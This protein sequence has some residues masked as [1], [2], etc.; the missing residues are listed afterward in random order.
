MP[1]IDVCVSA[2]SFGSSRILMDIRFSL[3]AGRATA[4][5]G[6]SGIGKTTLLRII[7]G[8]DQHFDGNISGSHRIGMVFQEPRLLP[9]LTASQNVEIV[10]ATPARAEAL[11]RQVGLPDAAALYPRQLS[12]GMARRAALARALAVEPELLILDEPFASLDAAAAAGLRSLVAELCSAGQ[13]TVL[14]V[15]HDSSDVAALADRALILSGRPA[16]LVN[17]MRFDMP[18]R[19]RGEQEHDAIAGRLK[20]ALAAAS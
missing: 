13:M 5:L 20:A 12:L 15:S 3:E 1:D 7:A 10:G 2:K 19:Q 14:I 18:P 9:W 6:D 17:D 16:R 4:V 11:L 8:L